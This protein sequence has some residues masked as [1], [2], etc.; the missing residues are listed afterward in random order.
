MLRLQNEYKS[1]INA[2]MQLTI[3]ERKVIKNVLWLQQIIIFLSINL[4]IIL[5]INWLLVC[6]NVS[7]PITISQSPFFC[8]NSQKL[9][10]VQFT[11]IEE[12]DN[13]E[14]FTFN[15]LE[16]RNFCYLFSKLLMDY[17]NC[18]WW[19]SCQSITVLVSLN[20]KVG[21]GKCCSCAVFVVF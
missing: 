14:I 4:P 21:S 13:Q 18:C 7:L 16:P 1:C 8:P 17:Q 5:A 2:L 12:Q 20:N 6:K 3:Y 15:R 11:V 9:K 10:D 19:I